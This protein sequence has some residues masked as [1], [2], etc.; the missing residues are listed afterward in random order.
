MKFVLLLLK[1]ILILTLR[2]WIKC[3]SEE[4]RLFQFSMYIFNHE[5][6]ME[7]TSMKFFISILKVNNPLCYG[8][9]G[10]SNH[11]SICL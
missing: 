6:E 7:M 10:S 2:A 11:L 9:P 3:I 4:N 1:L 5:T 8:S